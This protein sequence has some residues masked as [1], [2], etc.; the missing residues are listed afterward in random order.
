MKKKLLSLLLVA[1]MGVTMLVGCGGT[2]N[3]GDSQTPGG[4]QA[5]DGKSAIETLIENSQGKT[6]KLQVWCSEKPAYQAAMQQVL[7]NFKAAY[8]TVTFEIS[9]GAVSEGAAKDRVLEDPEKAADI[10]VFADDQINTLVGANALQEITTNFTYDPTKTNSPDSVGATKVNDKMYAYP[11]T[12]SN[13]YFLYYDSRYITAEDAKSWD[14]LLAAAA[15]AGK[16]VGMNMGDAWYVYSFF[17]GADLE[18]YKNEDGSNTCEWDCATGLKVVEAMKKIADHEAFIS[19]KPED[20]VGRM[21]SQG[22]IVAFIDGTWDAD[23]IKAAYAD[24]YAATKLPTFKVDGKDVQMGSF[25]GYKLVGVNSYA[26]EKAWAMAL[27]EYITSEASQAI[28]GPA[29]TEAPA[30]IE[31]AKNPALAENVALKGLA[32]Q[33]PFADRQVVGDNYW[34]PAATLGT[35]IADGTYTNAD[36]AQALKDAVLGITQPKQ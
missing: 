9:L 24:G 8:P 31:A 32:E 5:G 4:S 26:K 23:P 35:G 18:M 36:L 6:V 10:F 34:S 25:A 21:A 29:V 33:S 16:K 3:Q 22:D 1:A 17:A 19:M 15:K 27:A 7:D 2:A 30:N 12:A 28:I 20:A 13:G 11:F 14:G